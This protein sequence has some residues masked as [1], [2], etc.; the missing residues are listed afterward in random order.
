VFK[1]STK[2]IKKKER[3]TM[4]IIQKY[5]YKWMA[6]HAFLKLLSTTTFIQYCWRQVRVRNKFKRL[7]QEA[8]ELPIIPIG[9][10]RMNHLEERGNNMIQAR[11]DLNFGVN[12]LL[13]S[14]TLSSITFNS[15]IGLG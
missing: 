8:Q 9:D 15:I 13:S 14:F 5:I 1:F 4:V 12:F 11:S 10:S 6:K 2:R 3:A 7:Q